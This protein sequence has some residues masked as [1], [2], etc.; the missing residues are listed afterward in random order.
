MKLHTIRKRILC[1][2]YLIGEFLSCNESFKSYGGLNKIIK[3][4]IVKVLSNFKRKNLGNHKTKVY[5]TTY[6]SK[7]NF[8]LYKSD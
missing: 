5:E 4:R 3:D 6:H 2:T 7:E 8:M 1:S